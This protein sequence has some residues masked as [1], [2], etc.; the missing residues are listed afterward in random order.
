VECKQAIKFWCQ[1]KEHKT[2]H[3]R[4]V[5]ERGRRGRVGVVCVH[6]F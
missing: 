3:R 2:H 4:E 5:G 6:S 1:M